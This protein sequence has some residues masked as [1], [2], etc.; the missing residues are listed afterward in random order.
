MA[1]RRGV[2]RPVIL[3]SDD[4]P[5][6]ESDGRGSPLV[7]KAVSVAGNT[8]APVLTTLV[9]AP[10][11]ASR[12]GSE[13]FGVWSL[14]STSIA[15]ASAF[16]LGL[17]AAAFRFV[18]RAN[19]AEQRQRVLVTFSAVVALLTV[20][21][22][23]IAYAVAEPFAGA[24]V[25][26][27]ARDEVIGL[28]HILPILMGLPLVLGM[29]VASEQVA[30]R[31]VRPVVGSVAGSTGYLVAV[32]VV[33]GRHPRLDDLG[34]A[35]L[36]SQT[37]T[38]VVMLAGRRPVGARSAWWL[39]SEERRE[40]V[41]F[42]ASMQA[43][44]VWGFVNLEADVLIVAALLP[45]RDIGYYS[46]A[47]TVAGGLRLVPELLLRPLYA[48][49]S[50][51]SSAHPDEILDCAASQQRLWIR[52]LSSYLGAAIV[53]SYLGTLAWLGEGFEKTALV[54]AVLTLG[55]AVNLGTGVLSSLAR[56]LGRPKVEARYG[57]VS[58]L[59]NI[60]LTAALVPFLG[61]YGVCIG[62]CVGQVI[63]SLVFRRL[64][65]PVVSLAFP[66]YV[67]EVVWWPLL[68]TAAV[69]AVLDWTALALAGSGTGSVL[70]CGFLAMGAVGVANRWVQGTAWSHPGRGGVR[71][72]PGPRRT[73]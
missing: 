66:D 36:A 44:G 50:A 10:T 35:L 15:L 14:V 65:K 53:L 59:V 55:N 51:L 38:G 32:F 34:L 56:T 29:L 22:V 19:D 26:Q 67:R 20:L 58:A 37:L 39:R 64:M 40:A 31:F 57:M 73:G 49:L 5:V 6:T 13:R 2:W 69:V 60:V 43:A 42:A 62:T 68:G 41:R 16:D 23:G 45:V 7:R 25:G 3:T 21:L 52:T 71:A 61:L 9:V 4:R 54:A 46:L 63:G 17:G 72:S 12:L 30:D 33:L 1:V 48:E 27:G 47:L 28:V 70:L 24:L 18:G 11:L 8:F